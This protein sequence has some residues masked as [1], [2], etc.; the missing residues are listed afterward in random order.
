[1][2]VNMTVNL[3]AIYSNI[4]KLKTEDTKRASNLQLYQPE[5]QM[6]GHMFG[7]WNKILPRNIYTNLSMYS[8]S[9][10]LGSPGPSLTMSSAVVLLVQL[11][12]SSAG[13]PS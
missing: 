7:K 10:N 13:S 9:R 11:L 4:F 6:L 2:L 5:F 8:D 1:M 12:V 3:A